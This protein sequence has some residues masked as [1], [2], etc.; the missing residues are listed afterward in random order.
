MLK[1]NLFFRAG[2]KKPAKIYLDYAAATPLDPRVSLVMQNVYKRNFANPSSI[3]DLGTE[4]EKILGESRK[5]VA[6]ILGARPQEIIFTSGSTESNNLAI[7]GA[8]NATN[9]K[10]PHIVT[11]N[12]EHSSVLEICKHLEK[13]K[14]ARVTYVEAEMDG[15]VNPRKIRD[16]LEPDT[17][18]VSVMYANSEIG[19]IEP[20]R[21]IAKEIRH[22]NKINSKKIVFHTDATQA[23]NYL[24]I[25]VPTLGV[26]LMTLNS[27]KFYG[28]KGVGILYVK[29]NT[30]IEK[31]IWGGDQQF[32]LRP[33]SYNLPGIAGLAEALRVAEKMKKK[34]VKRLT[35]LRDYFIG[36]LPTMS[37]SLFDNSSVSKRLFDIVLV[38]NGDLK[39]RLPNN[40]NITI[41]RI[42]SDLLVIELS[43][44]GVMASG[45]SACNE[46]SS[47]TSHV[48]RA[49]N[50][51]S[52][53]TDLSRR[54]ASPKLQ[55]GESNADEDGSLRFSLGRQTTKRDIDYTVKALSEILL[56]LKKW[57]RV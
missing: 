31:I 42:P 19:T 14:Q 38:V 18:L 16:A 48:I 22:Y 25:Q 57:Y 9:E 35:A 36:Q 51:R 41:P 29:K 49:I 17:I 52:K 11:T 54:L 46:G 27:A 33:G 3:H 28:P 26:D 8:I 50:K 5:S 47:E 34:E 56:K 10:V 39:N 15:I 12:I 13:K 40:V 32:G 53:D 4:A 45:G 1:S 20:I 7:M 21:K 55:R 6:E 37:K 30:A 24:P 23:V 2:T 43:A 44:R